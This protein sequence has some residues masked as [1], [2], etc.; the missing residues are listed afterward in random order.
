V[1]MLSDGK[2]RRRAAGQP[3]PVPGY[4]GR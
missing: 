2:W 1:Y 4:C 3:A